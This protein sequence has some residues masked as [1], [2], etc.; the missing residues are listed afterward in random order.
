MLPSSLGTLRLALGQCL[1]LSAMALETVTGPQSRRRPAVVSLCRHGIAL[2]PFE[3][4]GPAMLDRER[5]I[6]AV[7]LRCALAERLELPALMRRH[8]GVVVAALAPRS[9]ARCWALA[10]P[11]V[12][13]HAA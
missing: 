7:G 10:R 1:L 8:V 4:D 6:A 3:R 9:L 2:A 13:C 5:A 11:T 12:S